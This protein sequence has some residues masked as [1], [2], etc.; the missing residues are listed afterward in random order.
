MIEK[1]KF[2]DTV[3]VRTDSTK[4]LKDGT[5]CGVIKNAIVRNVQLKARKTQVLTVSFDIDEGEFKDY[6]KI[7]YENSAAAKSDKRWL[8]TMDFFLDDPQATDEQRQRSTK[9]MKTFISCVEKSNEDYTFDWNEKSLADKK[10]G[11]VFGL[12]EFYSNDNRVFTT[13]ELRFFRTIEA[14]K[15]YDSTDLSQHAAVRTVENQFVNY[16]EYM[17]NKQDY[18][19]KDKEEDSF[20]TVEDD[21]DIPF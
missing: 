21:D 9:K 4:K 15:E 3:E 16:E 8:C 6:F 19:P 18:N 12:K 17:K 20:I 10:V 14:A 11:L 1:P 13:P 2:Y 5:Y 7:K